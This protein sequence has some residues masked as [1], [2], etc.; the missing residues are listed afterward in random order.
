M[1][2]VKQNHPGRVNTF[3]IYPSKYYIESDVDRVPLEEKVLPSWVFSLFLFLGAEHIDK[4]DQSQLE[5]R[6]PQSPGVV[7]ASFS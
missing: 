6:K 3:R 2:S 1:I 7:E 4:S 5:V